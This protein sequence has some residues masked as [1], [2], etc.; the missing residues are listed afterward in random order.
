[1][2][3]ALAVH[4]F[5]HALPTVVRGC[6]C[7]ETIQNGPAVVVSVLFLPAQISPRNPCVIRKLQKSIYWSVIARRMELI[8]NA[9]RLRPS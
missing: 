6:E 8:P 9:V 5:G 3:V 1:M 7:F 2:A 4:A